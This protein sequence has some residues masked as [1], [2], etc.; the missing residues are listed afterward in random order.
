LL[1][2]PHLSVTVGTKNIF[3]IFIP[4]ARYDLAILNHYESLI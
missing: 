4:E 1:H 2:L 3:S